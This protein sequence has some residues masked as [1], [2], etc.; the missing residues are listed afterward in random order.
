MQ[1]YLLTVSGIILVA[2]KGIIWKILKKEKNFASSVS[3]SWGMKLK[4]NKLNVFLCSSLSLIEA[5]WLA[6]W[7]QGGNTLDFKW[8][9]WS[10]GGKYQ[11]PKKSLG[12]PTNINPPPKKYHAEF[13]SLKNFHKVSN[14]K[15]AAKHW[16][17]ETSLVLLYSQNYAAGICWRYHESSDWFESA[18]TKSLLESSQPKNTAK[19][20][21][22]KNPGI[23]P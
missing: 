10:H 15:R 14:I 3:L 20:S 6:L 1:F 19:L 8:Q 13:P 4:W 22:P 5:I 12:P 7:S 11:N 21:C 9:G 16:T 2:I 17:A 18:Q 23:E